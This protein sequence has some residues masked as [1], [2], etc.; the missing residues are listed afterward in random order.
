LETAVRDAQ[1]EGA[2]D[3]AEDPGQLA[4]EIEAAL[5]LANAQYVVSRTSQP[6][7]RARRAIERRLRVAAIASPPPTNTPAP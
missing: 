1:A 4:F 6:I 3:S 2:I 5:L 7:E